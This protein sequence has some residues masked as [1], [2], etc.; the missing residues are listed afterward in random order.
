MANTRASATE[1][2]KWLSD[3]APARSLRR[4]RGGRVRGGLD[5]HRRQQAEEV[6]GD[7]VRV[8]LDD[9]HVERLPPHSDGTRAVTPSNGR[10][11]SHA[12]TPLHRDRAH[13]P[14]LAPRPTSAR[15][16]AQSRRR[17]YRSSRAPRPA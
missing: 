17:R 15:S 16:P 3:A 4:R 1:P 7:R 13:A 6:G 12:T 9:E 2:C 10:C 5:A 14:T 8:R 11:S